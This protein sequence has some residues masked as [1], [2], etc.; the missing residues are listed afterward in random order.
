MLFISEKPEVA[1]A[2]AQALGGN[3]LSKDGYF[4]DG[5]NTVTWCR[6]HMLQLKDPEDYDDKYKYW[7]LDDLPFFFLPY[8]RKNN[9]ST[10]KQLKVVKT[11]IKESESVVNAGDQDDE[12]QLIVDS[13]LRELKYKNPVKRVFTP[14]LNIKKVK[15]ALANMEDNSKHECLGYRAEARAVADQLFGY[16][17]TRLYTLVHRAIHGDKKVISIG[18]VQLTILGL[19]VRRCRENASHKK[20]NYYNLTGNFIIDSTAF[21]GK[22]IP[23]ENQALDDKK[24]LIDE[25][26][27][28]KIAKACKEKPAKV[29]SAK[30]E[31]KNTP[32]PL[33]YNLL[34]LQQDCSKK[35]GYN[36]SKTLDITQA[37]RDKYKLITYNRSDSRYLGEVHHENA[38][39]VLSC[40]NQN[41]PHLNKIINSSDHTIKGRVFDDKNVTAHHAII[42]TEA[43]VD[44]SELTQD[45]RNVY[46]LISTAYIAQFYP[47]YKYLQTKI[48]VEVEGYQF[49]TI[50]NIPT[51]QGWKDIFNSDEVEE[52]VSETNIDLRQLKANDLGIC[53]DTKVDKETTKPQPLY[54]EATLAGDL[55]SAAK[56]V[57]D[58]ELA[59]ILRERDKDKKDENGGIGT[60]ATRHSI[61][62][63]LF[64]RGYIVLEKKKLISTALG[65][66]LYDQVSDLL[67]FPD[68]TAI[69]T[70]KFNSIQTHQD[71]TDFIQY[72]IKEHITPE[73]EQLK[74]SCP[75]P[76]PKQEHPCPKC[77]RPM[78][79]RGKGKNKF[80]SCTGYYDKEN[81]CVYVMDDNNG[82]PIEKPQKAPAEL[83][84]HK[85][86]KCARP[87]IFR[88]GQYG[89][90]W[91]CSGFF[92]KENQCKHMMK[93]DNGTPVEKVKQGEAKT[94]Q[95]TSTEK[96]YLKVSFAD[97]DKVKAL[98]AKWDNDKKSWYCPDGVD[99][100]KFS[101]WM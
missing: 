71:V 64:E 20:S 76:A 51:Q 39:N 7:R 28:N 38:E 84:E 42:P 5:K 41:L 80:W 44:F 55:S 59:K 97:K 3:F 79:I 33:P 53:S 27:V 65:E 67:R 61:V 54:T 98:G 14:D 2:I 18:R 16:N 62:E 86:T 100:S 17:L 26:Q 91:S 19:I 15:E 63:T 72:V 11:L 93:D 9:P 47:D 52:D 56:Y 69:W 10:A 1:E 22:F 68:L 24:R 29:I 85:C 99:Q 8:G 37:L 60:P 35:F 94:E 49:A 78:Q 25:E 13:L 48:T 21:S 6:G 23:T 101:K 30:T 73:I 92:D 87:L 43:V 32:A 81:Q 34:K 4:T 83:S 77:A 40:V 45:E 82:T 46:E 90:Y 74:Q 75:P 57:R 12:G 66:S 89:K 50:S 88:D 36:L 31:E 95:A 70:D 96:T 58:P